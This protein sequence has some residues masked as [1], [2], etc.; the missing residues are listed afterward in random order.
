LNFDRLSSI[1]RQNYFRLKNKTATK[2]LLLYFYEIKQINREKLKLGKVSFEIKD[3]YD[4]EI[5]LY[6]TLEV[7]FCRQDNTAENEMKLENI[8]KEY[9]WRWNF[10]NIGAALII[11]FM[12]CLFIV[13]K[14]YLYY[15]EHFP[16]FAV[17]YPQI[18]ATFSFAIKL[19]YEVPTFI[20]SN[21]LRVANLVLHDT[22][23]QL[24]SNMD[25]V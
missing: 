15:Y 23:G 22:L 16:A 14:V 2:K 25:L 3:H 4:G 24:I 19:S 6:E 17:R 8:L 21:A 11:F 1:V 7:I 20:E 18:D 9:E 10:S 12:L 5:L 13:Y